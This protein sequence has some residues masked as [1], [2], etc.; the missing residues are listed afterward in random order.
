M[1]LEAPEERIIADDA[2]RRIQIYLVAAAAHVLPPALVE[3]FQLPKETVR[4]TAN[5]SSSADLLCH[6]PATIWRRLLIGATAPATVTTTSDFGLIR[7][8]TFN[9]AM[10]LGEA[11][12]AALEDEAREV[13]SDIRVRDDGCLLIISQLHMRRQ[14]ALGLLHCVACGVFCNGERGLR[15]H[16]HIKHTG[17]YGAAQEAVAIAKGTIVRYTAVGA[18]LAELWAARAQEAERLKKALPL[19][20]EAARDG[21]LEALRQLV[22]GGWCATD[23]VDRHGS[24]ALHYAA[25]SGRLDVCKYLMDELGVPAGQVQTKD[26]R[27]A[28]HWAA[29]NGWVEVCR[30]LVEKGISPDV[31]TR[32]G[33]RPLHWAIWQGHLPVCD[34][35]LEANADLHAVNSY[36]CNAIQ[37]AA[38]TDTSDGLLACRWL[39]VRGLDV[40]VLNTNG[41]SALHKA[42]VKGQRAVCEWLLSPDG[43]RLELAHLAAD[44]DGNTPSLMARL[45]GHVSLADYL[46]NVSATLAGS[47]R[48]STSPCKQ[49]RGIYDRGATLPRGQRQA[50]EGKPSVVPLDLEPDMP[51]TQV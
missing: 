47:V 37:W 20:L 40:G 28:L 3:C 5:A 29:R 10:E 41:H 22:A 51:S 21:D 4:R 44:G 11:I 19:G 25:G 13:A 27:T 7:E 6:A 36:G 50:S 26:G 34:F 43:G 9:T 16:Q 32:D 1:L 48:A 15:D 30:W 24:S 12:I 35:L 18:Q 39:R 17:D 38:Q 45:E 33:T 42:A 46:D 31:G 23:V 14:R 49:Q 8:T 2:R